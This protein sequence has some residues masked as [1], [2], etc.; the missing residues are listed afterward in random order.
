MEN[1]ICNSVRSDLQQNG[2]S[3][4]ERKIYKRVVRPAMLYGLEAVALTK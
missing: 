2:T 4:S 3:K 1:V